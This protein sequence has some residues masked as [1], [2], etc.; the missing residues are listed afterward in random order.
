[1]LLKNGNQGLSLWEFVILI[2]VLSLDGET[3]GCFHQQNQDIPIVPFYWI[4]K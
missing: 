3:V 4:Q 1:L 2:V